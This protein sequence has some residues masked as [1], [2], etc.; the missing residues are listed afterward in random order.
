MHL[1]GFSLR[2]RIF[3]KQ[4]PI[5]LLL[6]DFGCFS[7]EEKKIKK[8]Q[9]ISLRSY[10]FA[11]R[12]SSLSRIT[13]GYLLLDIPFLEV[14]LTYHSSSFC[15]K[16]WK[17]ITFKNKLIARKALLT[18]GKSRPREH[19]REDVFEPI[20]S[21]STSFCHKIFVKLLLVIDTVCLLH[22]LRF[23]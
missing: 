16:S 17:K 14:I 1:N 13:N 20:L 5:P 22:C 12:L 6:L 21:D 18:E 11:M 19:A 15:L 23:P 2:R 4:W 9:V 8:N 7:P 10:K 3:A